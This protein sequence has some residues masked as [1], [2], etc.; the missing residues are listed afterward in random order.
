MIANVR[1][2]SER[3]TVDWSG[4]TVGIGLASGKCPYGWPGIAFFQKWPR[5]PTIMKPKNILHAHVTIHQ[6]PNHSDST[7]LMSFGC[8]YSSIKYQ[9]CA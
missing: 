4:V 3:S 2:A 5:M 7:C 8:A 6:S 1:H 9:S